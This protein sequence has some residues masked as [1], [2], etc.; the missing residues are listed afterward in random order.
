MDQF[1]GTRVH[2]TGSALVTAKATELHLQRPTVGELLFRLN[3]LRNGD[4]PTSVVSPDV[5]VILTWL[6]R[7][8]ERMPELLVERVSSN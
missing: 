8:V 6:T 5:T 4:R 3:R 1:P 2:F 7:G